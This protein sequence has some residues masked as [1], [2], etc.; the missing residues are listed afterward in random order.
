[1]SIHSASSSRGSPRRGIFWAPGEGRAYRKGGQ[2]GIFKADG[3][4]TDNDYSISEWWLEPKTDG[5]G[6]HVNSYDHV[7]YVLEGVLTVFMDG[8][9][10]R[11]EKGACVVIPGGVPHDFENREETRV[12]F[13][14]VNV[15]G[16]F[17]RS[18]ARIF[19]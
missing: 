15:P 13:L 8:R 6:V 10:L 12:G 9:W 19:G 17:E 5:I 11:A 14:N 18:I 1:M 3:E 4:E 16:D 2:T 7:Y